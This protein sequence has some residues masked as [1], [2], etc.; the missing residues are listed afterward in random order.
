MDRNEQLVARRRCFEIASGKSMAKCRI[1]LIAAKALLGTLASSIVA[2][3]AA[4]K[5][6]LD[7]LEI[8]QPVSIRSPRPVATSKS[9]QTAQDLARRP[10]DQAR[11]TGI[12]N[13]GFVVLGKISVDGA[14]T[15]LSIASRR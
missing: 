9:I 2:Q 6:P 8:S 14:D 10:I 1:S 7:A 4:P 15:K 13:S 5:P 3:A 11:L 12:E